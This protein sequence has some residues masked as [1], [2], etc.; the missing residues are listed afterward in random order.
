[1]FIPVASETSGVPGPQSVKFMGDASK[2]PQMRLILGST[3]YKEFRWPPRGVAR[4]T[5]PLLGT[6]GHQKNLF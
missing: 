3:S 2:L 1:M 5:A 4:N 6:M